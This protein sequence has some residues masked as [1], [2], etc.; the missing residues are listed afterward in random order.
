[1]SFYVIH[2]GRVEEFCLHCFIVRL[3]IRVSS[4]SLLFPTTIIYSEPLYTTLYDTRLQFEYFS[5]GI[6]LEAEF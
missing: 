4:I 2:S 1:M 6:A 5:R 3:S